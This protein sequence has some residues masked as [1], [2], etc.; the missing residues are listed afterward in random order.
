[1]KRSLLALFFL[2]LGLAVPLTVV[3]QANQLAT[4]PLELQDGDTIVFLGDSITHQCLYTQYLEDF[5]YT[6]FPERRIRCHNAGVSGD[7]AA[8][9]L[10]RFDEDVAA[11]HPKI[12]TVLLGMNDGKYEGYDAATFAT[13]AEDMTGLLDR[14]AAIGARAVVMSPT[15][16]DHHQLALQMENPEYRFRE[17]SFDP[18]YNA[19]LAYYGGWLRERAGERGLAFVDQWGPMNEWTFAERRKKPDF[20]LV[21]DAIHPAPAGHLVMA[22]E[23]LMQ[24]P[25]GRD[26][27]GGIAIRPSAKGMSGSAGVTD[28]DM[29]VEADRITFS[30][31]ATALPW[32]V[33]D[34]AWTNEQKWDAEPGA[35]EGFRMTVAAHR[36]SNEKIQVVGLVP[37][38][39]A[40]S[41][42]G[43][44][45][46]EFTHSSLGFK[47]ELQSNEK[48]PQYQQALAVAELNRERNDLA[49]R[50][51][52]DAW[53]KIKGLRN[54]AAAEVA[55]GSADPLAEE[56]AKVSAEIEVLLALGRDYEDRIHAAAQ[57][58]ARKYELVKVP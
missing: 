45:V 53:G 15:M 5:F 7:K 30:H 41:I 24:A 3:A 32:V 39:Y 50:P 26:Y 31:L 2:A 11:L 54:K 34:Q 35:A 1:M 17:R 57:P 48:T 14:I 20:T 18:Y 44:N 56:L 47:V 33:P 46:G 29:S 28:L 9:A 21:P 19:L 23:L 36:R 16:F 10:A 43:V 49:T 58:V 12:V 37:G 25:T 13:Y 55:D 4:A 6:R 27:V 38:S 40:L 51:L 22:F 42:D 8:D 52:R